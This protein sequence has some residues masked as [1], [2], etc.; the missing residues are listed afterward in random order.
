MPY[1]DSTNLPSSSVPPPFQRSLKVVMSPETHPSVDDFTLLISTLTPGGGCTDT[2]GHEES[3]ELMVV[4]SG[5]GKAWLEGEEYPLKP[6]AVL[7]APPGAEHR[8]LN[9]SDEPMNIICVFVPPAPADYIR[10]NIEAA[11]E[12]ER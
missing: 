1:V 8:T 6:G 2:H 10:K 7:Y 3:G 4:T 11:S 12:G 5:E 9:T